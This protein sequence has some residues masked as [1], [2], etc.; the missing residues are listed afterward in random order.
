MTERACGVAHAPLVLQLTAAALG[1]LPGAAAAQTGAVRGV[2]DP[3]V[4]K[5]AG[6]YWLYATGRGV[7]IRRSTDLV[8]W[9]TAGR[10][11][12]DGLPPWAR[13]AVPKV[14]FPWAR[15]V[16]F[17]GGRWHLYYSL[18]SFASQHS[19]GG[20]ATNATLDPADPHYRWNDE[21][22]VVASEI[23]VTTYNAIDPNVAF[24]EQGRPWLDWGSFW[25][26]IK[27]RR[28][29]PATGK[30]STGDTTT[31]SLAARA[32]TDATDGPHEPQAIEGPYLVRHG[33]YYYLFV[34]FDN[35]CTG[36]KSDYNVRVGRSRAITGPYFDRDSIPMTRGGGTLV[37]ASYGVVRGPGHNSVLTD[38]DRY[39][40]V[41]HYIN[42]DAGPASPD[43]PLAIPRSLEV[44][45]MY[46]VWGGWP[47]AGEPLT[48]PA[49]P[50]PP[51]GTR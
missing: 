51:A 35:C 10:V 33:G 23:G 29:D 21:R 38:G 39:Y 8:H 11:F 7:P 17:S 30:I 1:S 22:R 31:Y 32:G 28:L 27:L 43:A 24:D 20:L 19:V 41:H 45:P 9:D 15:D 25:G 13:G 47:V 48:P 16:S 36:A 3:A 44:R 37:L 4:A 34:S 2:H 50:G 5:A 40:I 49:P 42:A 26:G 12:A 18:S 6:V 14:E 46:C